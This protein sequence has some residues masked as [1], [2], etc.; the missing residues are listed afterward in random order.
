MEIP[1]ER[2]YF[3]KGKIDGIKKLENGQI[4]V[5][6]YKTTSSL[7]KWD[8]GAYKEFNDI[9]VAVYDMLIKERYGKYSDR[10]IFLCQSTQENFEDCI[11]FY[12]FNEVSRERAREYTKELIKEIVDK[13]KNNNKFMHSDKI[14]LISNRYRNMFNNLNEGD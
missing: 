8:Y 10:F 11:S 5:I 4:I 6:D 9:Q 2:G 14:N 3:L 1:E 12:K 13:L 7:K